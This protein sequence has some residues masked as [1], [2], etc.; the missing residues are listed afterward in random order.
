MPLLAPGGHH[1]RLQDVHDRFVRGVRNEARR[2]RLFLGLEELIQCLLLNKVPCDVYLDGSFVTEKEDPSD[3]DVCVLVSDDAHQALDAGQKQLLYDIN[4]GLVPPGVDAIV[5]VIY[6]RGHRYFGTTADVGRDWVSC[7]G[8][9]HSEQW[10]KGYAVLR[11]W[12]TDVG[13]R[14]C[15]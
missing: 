9:E 8:L 13:L 10:L 5:Q 14:I 3:I 15:S 1:M 7:Y 2:E 12:E 6:G 11:L 4:T